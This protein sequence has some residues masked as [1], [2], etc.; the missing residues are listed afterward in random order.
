MFRK[1]LL[2][3]LAGAIAHAGQ[4]VERF[5]GIFE[6]FKYHPLEL[7]ALFLPEDPVVFEAGA[8]DGSDTC[9]LSKQWPQGTIHSFEPNPHAFSLWTEKTKSCANA[10]GHNL[11][12]N[13]YNGQAVF[14]VCHGSTGDNPVFEGASSLLES[15]EWM[16]QNYRGPEIVVPCVILDDWCAANS[17]DRIDFMWIDLEGFELQLFK[18]S[19]NILDTVRVI[20]TE[21]NFRDF[22]VGM[23]QYGELKEFLQKKGFQLL[24]HWYAEGFQGNAIF[25][26]SSILRQSLNL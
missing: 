8:F 9:N 4:Y 19:P 16:K 13:T 26:R 7:V 25:V 11:A 10:H 17:I 22:R 2:F 14:Y 15:S 6:D 5:E 3:L 23:T 18:S 21:T 20:Y 24:S 1:T 12:V